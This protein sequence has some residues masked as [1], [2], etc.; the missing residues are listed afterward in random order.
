M[1]ALLAVAIAAIPAALACDT[2]PARKADAA[3]H[4]HVDALPGS[5][6]GVPAGSCRVLTVRTAFVLS[7]LTAEDY[8]DAEDATMR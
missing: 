7:G 8:G 6:A 2:R 3:A 1:A 5:L 4:C